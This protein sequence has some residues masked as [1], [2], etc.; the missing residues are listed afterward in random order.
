MGLVLL[1][2]LIILITHLP[3][4]LKTGNRERGAFAVIWLSGIALSLY[5]L[6]GHTLPIPSVLNTIYDSLPLFSP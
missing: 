1:A 4:L 6:A 5:T 3:S 2:F